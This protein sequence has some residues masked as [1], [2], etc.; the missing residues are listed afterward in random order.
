MSWLESVATYLEAQSFGVQGTT[1]F[2]GMMPDTLV[3]TVLLTENAGSIIE[4]NRSGIALYQ[5]QLQIRVRGAKEDFTAPHSRI[6][7][8]QTAL[9]VLA[10]TTL[11]GIR[12]L[13]FKPTSTILSMGQDNNLRFEFSI[14]FEVTY[15]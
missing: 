4:T 10:D 2:I 3:T 7:A 12:F 5:P 15:E 9:S 11:S 13:R 14:N 1:L 6:M 8:I